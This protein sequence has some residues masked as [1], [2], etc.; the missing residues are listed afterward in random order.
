M[1]AAGATSS[2]AKASRDLVTE[3]FYCLEIFFEN[4]KVGSAAAVDVARLRVGVEGSSS[5][6]S[7]Y[8]V[9]VLYKKSTI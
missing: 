4:Q 6:D 2:G 7:I 9:N 1:G 3:S 5:V 8:I